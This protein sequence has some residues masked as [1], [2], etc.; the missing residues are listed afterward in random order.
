[1]PEIRPKLLENQLTH[2]DL[3]RKTIGC[4]R[5]N[6]PSFEKCLG[7]H[8]HTGL[9]LRLDLYSKKIHNLRQTDVMYN[10]GPRR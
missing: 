3:I 2:F 5:L 9:V 8:F 10:L 1:M 4:S 7:H 6:H